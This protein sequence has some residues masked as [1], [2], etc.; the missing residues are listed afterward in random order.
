VF[1]LSFQTAMHPK[2]AS[3]GTQKPGSGAVANLGSQQKGVVLAVVNAL[4]N[5]LSGIVDGESPPEFPA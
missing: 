1:F 2:Q 4:A 5:N 3:S